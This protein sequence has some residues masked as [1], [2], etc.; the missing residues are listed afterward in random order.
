MPLETDPELVQ[1]D[2]HPFKTEWAVRGTFDDVMI[3]FFWDI[4]VPTP[5]RRIFEKTLQDKV[6]ELSIKYMEDDQFKWLQR[7][8]PKGVPADTPKANKIY[9]YGDFVGGGTDA[10]PVDQIHGLLDAFHNFEPPLL[11]VKVEIG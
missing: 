7:T 3:R 2:R 8:R 6:E 5:S 1:P 4:P 9:I 11:F 10:D